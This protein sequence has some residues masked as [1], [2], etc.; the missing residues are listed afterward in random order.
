MLR[1]LLAFA[2]FL[3]C[4]A[5]NAQAQPANDWHASI[6]GTSTAATPGCCKVC[7]TGKPCGNTCIATHDTCSAAP[8]C[9]C[10]SGATGESSLSAILAKSQ[11]SGSR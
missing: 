8:G 2:F 10:K 1:L 7:T 5:A 4:G 3:S 11:S 9:A 6:S